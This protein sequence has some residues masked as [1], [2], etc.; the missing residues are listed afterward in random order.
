MFGVADDE[1]AAHIISR[2]SVPEFWSEAGIH[3]VPRNAINYGPTHGY[4]S[5]RRRLGRR[6][7]LVRV[8]GGARS[9]RSFMAYALS[10]SFRPLFEGPAT[11]Q[12]G[13]GAVFGMAARRDARQSRHDAFAVVSAA[14]SVGGDRRRRRARPFRQLAERQPAAG[15]RLEV[16][17]RSQSSARRQDAKLVRRAHARSQDLRE[18]PVRS[19]SRRTRSYDEDVTDARA[20]RRRCGRRHRAAQR[21]TISRFSSAI[22]ST[23]RL[24]HRA[25]TCRSYAGSIAAKSFN[26]LRGALDRDAARSTAE[27]VRARHSPFSS[28]AKASAC[29]SCAGGVA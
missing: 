28:T 2:L 27:A 26:S 25:V 11:Q 22:R 4:G 7:I 29:S 15:A 3:T 18:L 12:H 16:A 10:T 20:R 17:G 19:A 14:V 9:T 13:A 6:H 23:G 5:A 8:C 24:R 21:R 1:T